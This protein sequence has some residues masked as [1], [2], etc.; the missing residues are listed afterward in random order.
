MIPGEWTSDHAIILAESLSACARLRKL[1][2]ANNRITLKGILAVCTQLTRIPYLSSLDI[3]SNEGIGP[4]GFTAVATLSSLQ[5]LQ[6]ESLGLDLTT[7]G[8]FTRALP[9]EGMPR[10]SQ[11]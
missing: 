11:L 1:S 8:A 7:F 9:L 5:S 3:S 2:F 10:L 6:M 4:A